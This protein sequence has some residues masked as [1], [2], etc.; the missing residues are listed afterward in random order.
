MCFDLNKKA[1]LSF[2]LILAALSYSE[3]TEKKVFSLK[4]QA[5]YEKLQY[6]WGSGGF[7]LDRAQ[8]HSESF[9][10]K[11]TA[12][13][14]PKSAALRTQYFPYNG[15]SIKISGWIK[16]SAGNTR[17]PAA[18]VAQVFTYDENMEPSGG[19]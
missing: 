3:Q 6:F 5:D 2:L 17:Y 15:S 18:P 10:V 19:H 16:S 1:I 8:R 12:K 7:Q 4:T 13:Q 14:H 11:M 9:S